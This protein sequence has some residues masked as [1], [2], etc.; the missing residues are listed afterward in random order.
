M[1]AVE[2]RD[3]GPDEAGWLHALNEACL[4]AVNRLSPEAL[5]RL[6]GKTVSTRVAL[7]DG[8]PA[9]VAMTLAPGTPHDSINYGWFDARTPDFLYLDRIMVEE[10]ARGTGV[11]RALYQDVFAIARRRPGT[12]AVA[13][14]V[15]L[16]PFNAGSLRFHA[17]LGFV[18]VGEQ[19]SEGGAK[20]VCL[21]RRAI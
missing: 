11:G 7:L 3:I 6:V 1:T 8:R 13:C 14:E 5:W 10:R 2:I 16:R 12:R 15:N 19:D 18:A 4:P 17:A 20:A 9:G 21:M